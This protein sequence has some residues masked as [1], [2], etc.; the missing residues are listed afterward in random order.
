MNKVT[1]T[2]ILSDLEHKD[3]YKIAQKIR[4]SAGMDQ[5]L[6]EGEWT[7]YLKDLVNYGNRHFLKSF[8]LR[9]DQEED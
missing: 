5:L 4:K 1:T 7:G 2:D 8:Q 3:F 9:L 6:L